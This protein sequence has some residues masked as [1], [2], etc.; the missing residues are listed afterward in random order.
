[1]YFKSKDEPKMNM[2]HYPLDDIYI[3][4][5]KQIIMIS[6]WIYL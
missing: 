1:M 6:S 5:L 2:I 4:F 3:F